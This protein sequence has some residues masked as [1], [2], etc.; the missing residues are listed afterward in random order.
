ME[1]WQLLDGGTQCGWWEVFS[2]PKIV[3]A[4]A[5]PQR[6]RALWAHIA[7]EWEGVKR[8][9]TPPSWPLIN[10]PIRS[11]PSSCNRFLKD[12]RNTTTVK[13]NFKHIFREY[14]VVQVLALGSVPAT[15]YH[16]SLPHLPHKLTDYLNWDVCPCTKWSVSREIRI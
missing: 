5:L 10:L 2:A 9:Q 7:P 4:N 6:R 3:P 15:G 1:S 8:S 12:P 11:D 14:G 13:I 16:Q